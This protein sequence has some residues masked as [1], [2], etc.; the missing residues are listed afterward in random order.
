M[1]KLA[2]YF[3]YLVDYLKYGDVV[4]V[5]SSFRYI[6]KGESHKNDRLIRTSIGNFH[7]RKN[8][9][10]FQYANKF[11]EWGVKKF[12][13][14]RKNNFTVFIDG[15]ACIGDYSILMARYVDRC[16][17]FEPV[18]NNYQSLLG[19]I[20]LN[21]LGHKIK[22]FPF[23][24]GDENTEVFFVFNPVNTG[25]SHRVR[26]D[27][28]TDCKVQQRT[29]D[30]LLPELGILPSDQVLFKLDVEGMENEAI[31]GAKDFIRDQPG[32]TLIIEDKH[33]GDEAIKKT[34]SEIAPF[35]FG[36][37]DDYN[38]FARKI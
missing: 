10:D 8:T 24:L 9:N 12:I 35:E 1:K 27:M 29:M 6:R 37:I 23:A 7:C 17:A 25:A 21:N 2:T 34:L 31:R 18:S 4:S 32:L 19:N 13:L 16:I 3:R 14:D 33:S 26:D 38:I 28:P 11:Y 20:A 22:P 15:G 36:I 5:H 30:S